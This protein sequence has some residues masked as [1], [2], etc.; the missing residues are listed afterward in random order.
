[1]KLTV[2]WA[3]SWARGAPTAVL[4]C[5]VSAS[6]FGATVCVGSNAEL[7][8]ALSQAQ[9]AA[10]Q[11]EVISGTYDL[12]TTIW[13]TNGVAIADLFSGSSITG[14]YGRSC[15][16]RSDNPAATVFANS[17]NF[18]SEVNV[19]GNATFDNLTFTI[20]GGFTIKTE[21]I[22]NFSTLTVQNSIFHGTTSNIPLFFDW[23]EPT[24]TSATLR[25][26]N[27]L[28]FGNTD[29]GIN[30]GTGAITFRVLQG[31][32]KIE[33][34]NNTVVDSNGTLGAFYVLNEV[35][36]QIYA[37]NNIFYGSASLDVFFKDG[38]QGYLYNNDIGTYLV[39]TGQ[40]FVN[41]LR[42]DP[43][44]D[45]NFR[46]IE[47]PLS[48]VINY[49]TASVIDGLPSTDIVGDDR[50][51]G[52]KPD[53]G[54]SGISD[55][56]SQLVIN[57]NDS[58]PGSLRAAIDSINAYT[59]AQ[60]VVQ[61]AIAGACPHMIAVQ[62]RLPGITHNAEIFGYSQTGSTVNTLAI[63]DNSAQCIVLDGSAANL[64]T[65]IT[66]P[67]G[68]ADATSLE[69]QGIAFSGFSSVALEL[70][71]GS[72]H[73]V[74]GNRFGGRL[75][76]LALA[77]VGT[78]VNV[79]PGV[80]DVTIGGGP[81]GARNLFSDLTID[82]VFI[83]PRSGS[84]KPARNTQV[85]NNYFGFTFANGA[86]SAAPI[87]FNALSISGPGNSVT[88]NVIGNA[89]GFG[90]LLKTT[91]AHDNT[92]TGNRIG[93]DGNGAAAGTNLGIKLFNGAHDNNLSFNII[94]DNLQGGVVIEDVGT[95][96]NKIVSS[97]FYDNSGLGI[98]LGGDGVTPNDTDTVSNAGPNRLQN[99]PVLTA[100]TG[101]NTSGIVSGT[102]G[103]TAGSYTIDLFVSSSCNAS[104]YGEGAFEIGSGTL[105]L[106]G[107]SANFTISVSGPFAPDM[108]V[109]TATAT[110]SANDTSEFSKCFAY[111]NDT[112]FANDFEP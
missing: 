76:S 94:A 93:I 56:A 47:A 32:P 6:A 10:T 1:M 86:Q 68:V 34:V 96:H 91:D 20:P 63:G 55:S 74:V 25:V 31:A 81:S 102:L 21:S 24:T 71:G 103:S 107:G 30:N 101:T 11:I 28:F 90:I 100:A 61:F 18:Y 17:G 36:T 97:Q 58:G 37:Y 43:K 45:A 104:G 59:Y 106:T 69:V 73:V 51:V 85:T 109:I 50:Q 75:G 66:V 110:D 84:T 8:A 105:T 70:Q 9:T 40:A 64:S 35:P 53:L 89:A 38:S 41:T 65:A 111:T 26:A 22:A 88:N 3:I 95:V 62:S 87:A 46:P 77:P 15:L 13:S 29:G 16:S 7:A 12:T 33:A 42:G 23:R 98:D 48:P 57:T 82:G 14:G 72:E 27:S 67:A 60:T 5:A 112:I 39:G 92:I 52:S 49:G 44:L 78:A 99:F 54:A 80:H 108:N 79:D 2:L 83:A 19:L 4:M